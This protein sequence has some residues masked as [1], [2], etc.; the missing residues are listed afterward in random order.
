MDTKFKDRQQFNDKIVFAFLFLALVGTFIGFLKT[1]WMG[2]LT[3]TLALI[4]TGVALVLG[5]W[6]WWLRRLEL[7]VSIN[8]RRIKFKMSPFHQK[9]KRINWDEVASCK[10]V[11]TPLAAQWHGSNLHLLDEHWFSLSGRNGLSLLTRDG[12][13]YF[14]GCK[15]VDGLAHFLRKLAS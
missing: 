7:K 5:G 15:D 13:S 3:L 12:Q 1:L 6:F 14:I 2:E 11:K 4:Y 9:S 10:V 8:D